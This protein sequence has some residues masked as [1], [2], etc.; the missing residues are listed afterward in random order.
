MNLR[1]NVRIVLV[2]LPLALLAAL[3]LAV[4]ASPRVEHMAGVSPADIERA[5]GLLRAHDPRRQRA[6]VMRVVV[7]EQRDINLLLQHASAR[8]PGL[9][10]AVN[11]DG[12]DAV[13]LASLPIGSGSLRRWL[14]LEA[15]LSPGNGPPD[16]TRLRLG[17]LP[18]PSALALPVAAWAL[19]RRGLNVDR[20]L[21]GDVV[22]RVE[23]RDGR[24]VV[25][26]AWREDTLNRIL[27]SVVP[28]P[29]QER[30]RA[31]WERLVQVTLSEDLNLIVPLDRLLP[32]MFALA[33]ERSAA[34]GDEVSENRAALLT[35][36][37]YANRRG[38]SVIVPAARNWPRP[39]GLFVTLQGRP[40]LPLHFLISATIA[41]Q[42]GTP[43]ADAV[44]V[45]KEVADTRDGSGF[46]FND[47]A[48]DRA[49]TR[50]GELAV[51]APRRL[52]ELLAG[53]VDEVHL[54]PDV[55]D[56]PEFLSA[57]EFKERF[58]AVGSPS[59]QRL[60]ADIESRLD[61][62]PVLR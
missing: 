28:L 8:F 19:E 14:N 37:F 46:S 41:A 50:L 18:L 29:D 52:Q 20:R 21:V 24:I 45:Y 34:G 25:F 51:K 4:D 23:I 38:L 27:A 42:S 30:L 62:S 33:R 1:R 48:A 40:D 60:L 6:G 56:L 53:G 2:G 57:A 11:L 58:G 54:L 12:Q 35:L 7:A 9:L 22:K 55:T 49:G 61:Q 39:R 5:L 3:L 36:T 44:G 59:Y 13:L 26:Y 31:Y 43:L 32:P 10:S 47:L 15:T 16:V 17:S